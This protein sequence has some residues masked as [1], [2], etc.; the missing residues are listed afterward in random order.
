MAEAKPFPLSLLD[1]QIQMLLVAFGPV[2]SWIMKHLL[3][4]FSKICN[5]CRL[6]LPRGFKTHLTSKSCCPA[7]LGELCSFWLPSLT[8]FFPHLSSLFCG[9][10]TGSNS[11]KITLLPPSTKMLL[12]TKCKEERREYG[13]VSSLSVRVAPS[14]W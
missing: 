6:I 12:K 8:P 1:N 3:A 9:T 14:L 7:K 11:P 4:L 10:R 2:S 5:A 13:H